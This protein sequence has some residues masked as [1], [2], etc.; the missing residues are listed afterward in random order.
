MK[1]AVI[2]LNYNSAA[3]CAKCVSF[4]K[5][6][7]NVELEI[8]IVDNLSQPKDVEAVKILCE[9]ESCT[10]LLNDRNKGYSAGNNIGL[11][12]A[13]DKGYQY[14]LI[15]NPDMEFPQSDYITSM[16]EAIEQNDDIV[17]CGSDIRTPE[18]VHQNPKASL[19]RDWRS[20]FWW[21]K[22]LLRKKT[23]SDIPDWVG[24]PSTSHLC[25]CL[26]GC[27]IMLRMNFIRQIGFLDENTFLYGEEPIL[28][29]QVELADKKMYY[30][31]ERYAIHDHKKSN[32]GSPA[33][34]Q[35]HWRHS[36]LYY[37]KRYSGYSPLGKCVA[38]FSTS[39][40]FFLLSL[41]NK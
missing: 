35:K 4:L 25:Q 41:K 29:R 9:S 38:I 30:Y 11:R 27:C 21:V 14:A 22:A 36:Q 39:L 8:I 24:D 16:I 12:Y 31:G 37:I 1:V 23:N 26:N 6:Q 3:D 20:S 32:E 7:K 2:L 34:C 13:A 40:Y 10:L 28:G 19:K 17:V 15:A 33:F 18:G 5:R